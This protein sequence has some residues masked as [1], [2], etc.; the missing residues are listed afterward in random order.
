MTNSYNRTKALQ[1]A[2]G[3]CRWICTNGIIFGE[4]SLTLRNTHQK[5]VDL[6]AML[7]RAFAM[8]GAQFNLPRVKDSI[9]RLTSL[10]VAENLFLAGMLEIL[11]IGV[12]NEIPPTPL[13]A[14]GWPELGP[15]LSE[16][17]RR[18]VEQLGE[19]AYALVNAESDYASDITAPRMNPTLVNSRQSRCGHW[20]EDVVR[21]YRESA[22]RIK[23]RPE[24][25]DAARRLLNFATQGDA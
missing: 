9:S 11:C 12:P 5:G 22:V 17:G 23:F 21:Q 14:A 2:V 18:Y 3:V 8:G 7:A 19:N 1:F 20:A 6:H 13:Q 10:H 25:L 16:L 4:Q 24:N 15:H